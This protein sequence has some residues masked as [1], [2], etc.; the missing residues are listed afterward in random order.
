MKGTYLKALVRTRKEIVNVRQGQVL[1][2]FLPN[3]LEEEACLQKGE[4]VVF[5]PWLKVVNR[6]DL[7]LDVVRLD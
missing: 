5:F 4:H 2:G 7:S 1:G 3:Q 6:S